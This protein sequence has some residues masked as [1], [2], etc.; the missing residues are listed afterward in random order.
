MSS[1]THKVVEQPNITYLPRHTAVDLI[2]FPHHAL[3][4][5]AVYQPITC[6]GAYVFDQGSGKIHPILA[7]HTL[8]ATGGLGQI[9]LNTSNPPGTRGDGLAM[10]YRAGARVANCEYIQFHPTTLHMPG[11]TKFLISEAV[12]GEGGILL[13]PDGDRFMEKYDPQWKELAPRDVVARAIYWQMLENDY[14]YVLLDI[15]SQRKPEQIRQRFPHIYQRCLKYN[16][17]ISQQPVPV[18]PSAHY[19]CGGV[20]V[21]LW[22]R[23]NIP[24][25]YAVGGGV[26]HRCAW[27]QPPGKHFVAGRPAVGRS[28]CASHH[29]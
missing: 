11:V 6:H 24:G 23:T 25:L 12:R 14:P 4:P 15:A 1:L 10:A 13:T 27:C 29:V 9:Y 3:D 2:T 18:V 28:R 16:L 7:R 22:G 19:F 21:D 8:L 5:L 20:L 26:L 17:D